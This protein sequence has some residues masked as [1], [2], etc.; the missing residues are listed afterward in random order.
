MSIKGNG[1]ELYIGKQSARIRDWM[2]N[3][4]NIEYDDL[5]KIE[6]SFRTLTEG[7]YMDFHDAYGHFERFYFPKKSNEAIQRAV[8]YIAALYPEM[9]IIKHDTDDDPFYAKNI[10]IALISVFCLWPVGI[11]LCW[12]TGKRT[13]KDKIVFTITILAIQISLY[14]FYSYWRYIEYR[15]A[16]DAMNN[17]VDQVQQMFR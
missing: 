17:I 13:T 2:Y 14:A 1:Q 11:I 10:F 7:G 3:T 9:E 15:N 6:Y 16:M 12:C 5:S 4:K 8:D